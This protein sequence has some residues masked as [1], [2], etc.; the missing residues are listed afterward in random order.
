MGSTISQQGCL[1]LS[2]K[3]G[4]VK[5]EKLKK[6]KIYKFKKEGHRLYML[7]TPIE[8]ITDKWE[9]VAKILM[10]E[11]TVGKGR[12]EGSYKV[13]KTFSKEDVEVI[14]KNL[15]PYYKFRK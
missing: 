15:I 7:N 8:L 13:I 10:I 2:K 9:F 4:L 1:K 6:G 5:R 11:F 14:S 12:T 3:Q